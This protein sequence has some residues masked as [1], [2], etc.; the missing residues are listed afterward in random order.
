MP[1]SAKAVANYFLTLAETDGKKLSPMKV[2]K[3]VYLAHGWHLG[4]TG[5]PLLDEQVQAW[6]FGPVIRSLYDEFR[7]F[8]P[9]DINRK[10][11][12]IDCVVGPDPLDVQFKIYQPAIDDNTTEDNTFTRRLLDRVWKVYGNY[13]A[14]QLA[15][16]THESDSPWDEVSRRYGGSIP[17]YTTI[18]QDS[19][20]E[21]FKV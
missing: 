9:D 15:N 3:L 8:G 20:R 2:Q 10:A 18:P 12:E 5:K 1:Y 6:S 16:M 17:K 19:I 7:E 13:S 11:V 14:V 21:F 4:L